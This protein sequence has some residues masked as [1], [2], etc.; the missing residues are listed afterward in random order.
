M[1][2]DTKSGK[3]ALLY[4]LSKGIFPT[5]YL[6]TVINNVNVRWTF[7][8]EY[9]TTICFW[10]TPGNESMNSTLRE[11][12]GNNTDLT[13]GYGLRISAYQ[14]ADVIIIAFPLHKL[15]AL[16][17]VRDKWHQEIKTHCPNA[18]IILVGTNMDKRDYFYTDDYL[19]RIDNIQNALDEVIDYKQGL[20]VAKDIGAKK[21]LETSAQLRLGFEDLYNEICNLVIKRNET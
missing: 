5:E 1:V 7:K 12:G 13:S 8:K 9:Q 16:D 18:P 19:C 3:T 20:K 2:G 10:D 11:N 4:T 6:P 17:Q 21:Y 14:N 15:Q